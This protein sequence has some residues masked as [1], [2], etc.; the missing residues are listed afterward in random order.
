MSKNAKTNS[1]QYL[2]KD[3]KERFWHVFATF[4]FMQMKT[5]LMHVQFKHHRTCEGFLSKGLRSFGAGL[6]P[7]WPCGVWRSWNQY[8]RPLSACGQQLGNAND[9]PFNAC[10][11]KYKQYHQNVGFKLI[12]V[13]SSALTGNDLQHCEEESIKVRPLFVEGG[14][15]IFSSL[16]SSLNFLFVQIHKCLS[17][18][19]SPSHKQWR[20][21]KNTPPPPPTHIAGPL[22]VPCRQYNMDPFFQF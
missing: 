2:K 7:V 8:Y 22:V 1:Y 13:I 18:I 21:T 6:W 11:E 10:H 12:L 19:L 17:K 15:S 4:F 14:M 16:I 3:K 5:L 9:S 20:V